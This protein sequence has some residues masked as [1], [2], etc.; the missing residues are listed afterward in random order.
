MIDRRYGR[1]VIA[2]DACG[3][4]LQG[5]SNEWA[6]IWLQAKREGR[7]TR[8]IGKNWC[9][10]CGEACAS[11]LADNPLDIKPLRLKERPPPW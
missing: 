3:R 9:Q 5:D 7:Q 8:K 11:K 10:F 6:E 4:L 2:C 1:N